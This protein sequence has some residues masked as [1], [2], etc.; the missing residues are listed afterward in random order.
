MGAKNIILCGHDCG[1]I[2]GQVT[3]KD[4]YKNISPVQGSLRHYNHWLTKS[5]EGHTIALKKK[6]KEI[7]GAN[8]FSLNPFINMGLEGHAYSKDEPP[9]QS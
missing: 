5:I 7:Y 1:T 4:Y 8:V 9:T 3:I 2:D 6:V